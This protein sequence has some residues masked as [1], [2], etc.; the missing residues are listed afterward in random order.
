MLNFRVC[1][2]RINKPKNSWLRFDLEKLKD[3]TISEEFQAAIVEKFAPLLLLDEDLGAITNNINTVTTETASEVLGKSRRRSKSWVTNK[4][5]DMCDTRRK[6]KK[7]KDTAEG[8]AEY[9]KINK[10]IRREMEAKQRWI[11]EQCA[12]YSDM[13]GR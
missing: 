9:R 5:L 3:L 12:D 10:E 13:V 4:I 1:L 6:L 7:D 8:R 2:R 11:A